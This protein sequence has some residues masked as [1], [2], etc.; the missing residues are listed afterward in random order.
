MFFHNFWEKTRA[1]FALQVIVCTLRRPC[2]VCVENVL[3]FYVDLAL[4]VN[5]CGN[6]DFLP[7]KFTKGF[8]EFL[9]GCRMGA[10]I[11]RPTAP[12]NGPGQAFGDPAR[13]G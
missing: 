13:P 12:A 3:R 6:C 11:V 1:A 2:I 5:F 8:V 10:G 7:L 9:M 4:A